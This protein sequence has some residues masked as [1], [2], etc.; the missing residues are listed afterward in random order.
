MEQINRTKGVLIG[1]KRKYNMK[2]NIKLVVYKQ[3]KESTHTKT[4]LMR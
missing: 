2:L 3:P 1:Y 4:R